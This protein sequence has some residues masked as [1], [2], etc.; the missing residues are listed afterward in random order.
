[1]AGNTRSLC[2]H[3]LCTAYFQPFRG[4]VRVKRHILR[5]V[6][7]RT[8]T[9]LPENTAEGGSDNTLAYVAARSGKHNRMKFLHILLHFLLQR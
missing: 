5:L 9:V 3:S 1:M 2:L 8:I 4:G 6:R 7:R